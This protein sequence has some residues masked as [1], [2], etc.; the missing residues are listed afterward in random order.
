MIPFR[1]KITVF[2][3]GA[4]LVAS[5]SSAEPLQGG[6]GRGPGETWNLFTRFWGALT[7]VWR[8]TGCSIDPY[9]GCA[10]IIDSPS[11]ASEALDNGC[12][13]DPDGRCIPEIRQEISDEGCTIDPNGACRYRS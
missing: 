12:T 11:S 2:L 1:R 3:L 13:I 9:G 6:A 5:L 10:G 7:M 8:E 4:F